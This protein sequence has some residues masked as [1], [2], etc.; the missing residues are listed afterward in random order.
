VLKQ[1]Q[2]VFL[3]F[4]FVQQA[5][6]QG[7]LD[8]VL[9][10]FQ[11]L[12]DRANYSVLG[13]VAVHFGHQVRAAINLLG[14]IVESRAVAWELAAHGDDDVNTG[15]FVSHGFEQQIDEMRGLVLALKARGAALEHDRPFHRLF[16]PPD[17][18][19]CLVRVAQ[20]VRRFH[21]LTTVTTIRLG[22]IPVVEQISPLVDDPSFAC[23][24]Q[25]LR[26]AVQ[27]APQ[28]A[29]VFR[30]RAASSFNSAAS[31]PVS[32]CESPFQPEGGFWRSNYESVNTVDVQ[33]KE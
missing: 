30:S 31:R 6:D 16:R 1:G 27:L 7:W 18:A 33:V 3:R 5:L 17:L 22:P 25:T 20:A 19:G 14:Q 15:V 11:M 10:A 28:K 13:R 26:G 8:G 23:T 32:W 2:L 12:L 9:I 21:D 24:Y 29:A 4:R